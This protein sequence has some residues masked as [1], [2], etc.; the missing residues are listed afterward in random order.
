MKFLVDS[1]Q[2]F[3]PCDYRLTYW[4]YQNDLNRNIMVRGKER[5]SMPIIY[6]DNTASTI[7]KDSHLRKYAFPDLANN[8][9]KNSSRGIVI[10]SEN[11]FID[12]T[13]LGDTI[14]ITADTATD[15]HL[16]FKYNSQTNMGS[17]ENWFA[18]YLPIPTAIQ[19]LQHLNTK[20]PKSQLRKNC[21]H[22]VKQTTGKREDFYY[23]PCGVNEYQFTYESFEQAK[24]FLEGNGFNG[25]YKGITFRGSSP[26]IDPFMKVGYV[27]T[28]EEDGDFNRNPQIALKLAQRKLYKNTTRLRGNLEK[29]EDTSN[30]IVVNK[31]DFTVAMMSA[32]SEVY[33][34]VRNN[35]ANREVQRA[36]SS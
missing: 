22:E 26:E 13:D 5:F 10:P 4:L 28:K 9:W 20:L 3:M 18:I 2:L 21:T 34:G 23:F 33:K 29:L 1:F 12:I 36:A 24:H 11:F 8:S 32:L 14:K 6:C 7:K 16:E 17:W 25:N 15:Y 30:H 19:I 35:D 31:H 27:H